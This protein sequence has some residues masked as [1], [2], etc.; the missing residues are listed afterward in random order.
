MQTVNAVERYFDYGVENV[1]EPGEARKD[2]VWHMS[3]GNSV[4]YNV[5]YRFQ[6]G[7][8]VK[9]SDSAFTVKTI[10]GTEEVYPKTAFANV[11]ACEKSGRSTKLVAVSNLGRYEGANAKIMMYSYNGSPKAAV[12]YPY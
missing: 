10:F 3:G 5:Y 2:D 8:I 12:I 7:D 9:V 4:Q 6:I 1:P 11:Y